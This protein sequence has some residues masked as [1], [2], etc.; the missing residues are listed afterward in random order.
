MGL[1]SFPKFILSLKSTGVLIAYFKRLNQV[2]TDNQAKEISL[3]SSKD[4]LEKAQVSLIQLGKSG[5]T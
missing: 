1:P 3:I 2:T 4:F 5:V